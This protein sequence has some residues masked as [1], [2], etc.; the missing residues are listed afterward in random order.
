[1]NATN[2][3]PTTAERL[4][5][6]EA[7]LREKT[8]HD[9]ERLETADEIYLNFDFNVAVVISVD[10]GDY[11]GMYVLIA[12]AWAPDHGVEQED[13]IGLFA[14]AEDAASVAVAFAKRNERD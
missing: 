12:Y 11:E 1:M 9:V 7:L 6:I 13:F 4:D 8:K 10:E 3:K 2:T 5:E 14:Y